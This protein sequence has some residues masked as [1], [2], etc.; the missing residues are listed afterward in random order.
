MVAAVMG[1]C[2][3]EPPERNSWSAAWIRFS[4]RGGPGAGGAF[5]RPVLQVE[6]LLL[7]LDEARVPNF[8]DQLGHLFVV[9]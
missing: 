2:P 5:E 4:A 3:N 9:P 7:H 8:S 1:Y 6:D